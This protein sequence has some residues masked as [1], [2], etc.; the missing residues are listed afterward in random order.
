MI[1]QALYEHL[2]GSKALLPF[3]TTYNKKAAIFNQEA[4]GDRDPLWGKG[5]Q[6][7]RIVFFVDIQGDAERTM[8]GMLTVD[9]MCK[10]GKQF[11]EEI[12]PILRSLIHGYF[13]SAGGATFAAQ[14]KS[15]SYFTEPTDHVL[16]CTL[17]FELLAFPLLTTASPDIIG[18][19]NAWCGGMK[20]LHVINLHPLPS[21][22]WKPEGND[23]AVYFRLV[24][25][26]PAGWIPDTFQTIW[27]TAAIRG[28]VFAADYEKAG[29]L[30][31]EIAVTLYQ[32]KRLLKKGEAPI[33]VNSKN[34]VQYGADPLRTGQL[35]IEATYGI[36]IH[37]EP[38]QKIGRI[39]IKEKKDSSLRSE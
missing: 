33:L 31:R 36:V 12:E 11:P 17:V 23:A 10:E 21:V 35:T 39:A 4:P 2:Q 22:A 34:T 5:P 24:K 29:A 30:A 25:D 16:G 27:R 7:G 32:E 18:R 8:G 6:Y 3:L 1:E 14:W 28:H 26:D 37:R 15:S 9:I 20:N 13:F 38:E 19:I